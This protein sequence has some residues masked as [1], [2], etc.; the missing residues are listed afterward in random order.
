MLASLEP[1]RLCAEINWRGFKTKPLTVAGVM[2]GRGRVAPPPR[3]TSPS[4]L[5]LFRSPRQLTAK[6][7]SEMRPP[8]LS[9]KKTKTKRVAARHYDDDVIRIFLLCLV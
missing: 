9:A 5:L 4:W 6:R 7:I 1:P 3:L 8:P 2:R